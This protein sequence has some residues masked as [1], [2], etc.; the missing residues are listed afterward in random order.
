VILLI[1]A[2][3]IT[4][5]LGSFFSAFGLGIVATIGVVMILVVAADLILA[6][7]NVFSLIH[8]ILCRLL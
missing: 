1:L 8:F 6:V 5:G 4:A 3:L 7:S 2:I